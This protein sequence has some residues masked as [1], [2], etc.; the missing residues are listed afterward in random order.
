MGR[1]RLLVAGAI[2]L[3]AGGTAAAGA[4]SG[5][6]V[7][8]VVPAGVVSME[9][10]AP[11]GEAPR[12]RSARG[13]WSDLAVAVAAAGTGDTLRLAGGVHRSG[14]VVIDRPVT[15]LG[16]PGAVLENSGGAGLL[17]I[18]ADG[19]TVRGLTLRGTPSSHVRDHAAVLVEG[20]NGCVIEGN[21]FVDNFFGIYLARSSGCRLEGNTLTA[22]GDRESSAG[23]GIHLW[24]A[25]DVIVTGNRVRGH[26]DGIYLEH[27][28][29]AS[30]SRNVSEDNLRYGLHFMF[31]NGNEY[32][33]NEFRRNNAGVAVMYSKEV[34]VR[35]NTFE[36]NWGAAAYGLLIKDIYDSVIS[37]NTFRRNTVAIS[38]EGSTRV[39]VTGN[40]FVRNGW[41]VRVLASSQE[42][43]FTANDFVENSFDV[44]TNSRQNYNTF[45]GNYWSRYNGYDLTG[46]GIGDVPH[47]PV[48]LF[49]LLV[50][51]SPAALVLLRSS[52]LDV[53]EVAERV[54]PVLTPETLVDERPLMKETAR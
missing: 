40:R 12:I 52:F 36:D 10:P 41:A 22:S 38:S 15:L 51:R 7:G 48:R 28:Q 3:F 21:A 20:A 45:D 46:D 1:N 30:L 5:T 33:A 6:A 49:A 32:I 29:G 9:A 43:R 37:G 54:A 19:V 53:L 16:E 13:E 42:N 27:V 11:G 17:H 8:A 50:Q 31:S 26:R 25:T 39:Q 2:A 4:R 47:R 35:G 24:N 44:T 23:N 14:T 34:V 18:T